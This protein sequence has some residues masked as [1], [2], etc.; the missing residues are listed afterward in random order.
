MLNFNTSKSA[1]Q[2]DSR[3]IH[4]T[5]LV[6]ISRYTKPLAKRLIIGAYCRGWL[7]KRRTQEL[8]HELGLGDCRYG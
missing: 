5:G 8:F 4:E 3:N 1:S 7:S 2:R 6:H